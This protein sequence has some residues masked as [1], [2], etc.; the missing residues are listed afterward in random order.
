MR[1]S[2]RPC[3]AGARFTD[4]PWTSKQHRLFEAAAHDPEVAK[5]VGIP[6]QKAGQMASEGVKPEVMAK[7]L[8]MRGARNVQK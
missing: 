7:A 3:W 2:Q 5:R 1:H 4:M 8:K 6:Q